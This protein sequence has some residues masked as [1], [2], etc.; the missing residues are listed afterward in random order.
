MALVN[1]YLRWTPLGKIFLWIIPIAIFFPVF[2][3]WSE[4]SLFF[5]IESEQFSGVAIPASLFVI[6]GATLFLFF[7]QRR[8]SNPGVVAVIYMYVLV[9]AYSNWLWV[10][11]VFLLFLYFFF[12]SWLSRDSLFLILRRVVIVGIVFLSLHLISYV[13]RVLMGSSAYD[14]FPLLF[15]APLYSAYVSYVAVIFLVMIAALYCSRPIRN[16]TGI[17]G[18]LLLILSQRSISLLLVI[19]YALGRRWFA[20][21]GV[22]LVFMPA[23][24]F[25]MP[26]LL[27][28][29]SHT[30]GKFSGGDVGFDGE[31]LLIWETFFLRIDSPW[32]VIFGVRAY[33]VRPHNYWLQLLNIGGIFLVVGVGIFLIFQLWKAFRNTSGHRLPFYLFFVWISFDTNVNSPLTQPHVLGVAM[34]VLVA[35]ARGVG[36]PGNIKFK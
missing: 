11:Q 29:F 33:D 21:F 23:L 7:K 3:G 20:M 2:G 6:G 12:Y 32:D 4:G 13:G 36:V 30:L 10:S 5:P 25:V 34:L 1:K 24:V 14:A 22:V 31:R 16:V 9:C 15:M 28:I 19:F 27:I 26:D 35:M 17:L 8:W 18:V